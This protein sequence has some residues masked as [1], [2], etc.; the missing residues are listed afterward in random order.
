MSMNGWKFCLLLLFLANC[1]STRR[2]SFENYLSPL[3]KFIEKNSTNYQVVILINNKTEYSNNNDMINEI[4]S[5]FPCL[6]INS[7]TRNNKLV[8]LPVFDEPRATSFFII[9]AN[10][11]KNNNLSKLNII[12]SIN[13]MR[14]LSPNRI[15]PKC[16]IITFSIVEEK[17]LYKELL[18]FMWLKFFL[19]TTIFQLEI[20]ELDGNWKRLLNIYSK[21]LDASLHSFNP[22]TGEYRM[23]KFS[24]KDYYH[25]W[26]PNKL[27]NMNG[28]KLIAGAYPNPP[29]SQLKFN[30]TG[31]LI[32][33]WGADFVAFDAIAKAMNFSFIIVSFANASLG[34]INLNNN[35]AGSM[36]GMCVRNEIDIL[37]TTVL[38]SRDSKRTVTE[39]TRMVN[40]ENVYAI[41]PIIQGEKKIVENSEL[42]KTFT[43]FLLVVAFFSIITRLFRYE[44]LGFINIIGV[45]TGVCVENET[46]LIHER[47]LFMSILFLGFLCGSIFFAG[48][49]DMN[50]HVT[51]TMEFNTFNDR[52]IYTVAKC[53]IYNA[54]HE[55]M[56]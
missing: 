45:L 9:I 54:Q 20:K 15:R 21:P 4:L 26:F 12:D 37:L 31:S 18:K 56:I 55:K 16:L 23:D 17:I 40:W 2:T 44:Q 5:K 10:E 25:Q 48:F 28:Y 33:Y 11:V 53:L 47:L 19:D 29:Y 27:Q 6:V 43:M 38:F 13:F 50:M 7:S 34:V 51:S 52:S 8:S 3:M 14:A 39:F 41:V 35:T 42:Y 24:H 30:A 36:L 32:K 1:E 22:F 46:S 49:T